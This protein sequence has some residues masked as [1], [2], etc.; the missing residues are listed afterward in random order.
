MGFEPILGSALKRR[1]DPITDP[2]QGGLD[3]IGESMHIIYIYNG[4]RLPLQGIFDGPEI[5]IASALAVKIQGV[6][7]LSRVERVFGRTLI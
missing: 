5:I 6:G 4:D 1:I 7:D 3:G 2:A